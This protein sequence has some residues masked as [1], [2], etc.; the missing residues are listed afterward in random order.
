[1]R[2]LYFY[3]SVGSRAGVHKLG[4]IY[5]CL[6]C[7]PPRFNSQLKNLFLTLMF[8]SED[9]LVYGSVPILR[10]MVE[11][12][13]C[14]QSRRIKLFIREKEW[15]IKFVLVQILGD[16]LGLNSTL[17]YTESFNAYHSCR[18]CRV[19]KRNVTQLFIEDKNLLRNTDNYAAD[20]IVNNVSETGVKT[21]AIWN[22]IPDFHVTQ[23]C[24]FEDP[25][26]YLGRHYP[27]IPAA[28]R[29]PIVMAATAGARH[30][31][32]LH[33][34]WEKNAASVDPAKRQFAGE[35]A[36]ALSFC[37]LGLCPT[38]RSGPAT[39]RLGSTAVPTTESASVSCSRLLQVQT[40]DLP[41]P[42]PEVNSV[43]T[44]ERPVPDLTTLKLP[45]PI[46]QRDH[47]FEAY[48]VM[49][50]ISELGLPAGSEAGVCTPGS[51]DN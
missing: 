18:V 43:P 11:E 17:G 8:Y 31:S 3:Y 45:V 9:R 40:A 33:S 23:N 10:T 37:A 21:D 14:L 25:S 44:G 39:P 47:E 16:N 49:S 28:L 29:G 42:V 20:L 24:A 48:Y 22:E 32:Q 15:E 35:A 2:H 50:P 7:F 5:A 46:P 12:I 27:K 34:M 4:A 1:L 41:A 13:K 26:S 51:K 36:S 6:K 19:N 30:A 38:S